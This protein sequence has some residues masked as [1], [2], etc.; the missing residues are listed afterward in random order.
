MRSITES[1]GKI[2]DGI[3]RTPVW[4]WILLFML[5]TMSQSVVT[6]LTSTEQ[7]L[8]WRIALTV[9]A[10]YFFT[11]LLLTILTVIVLTLVDADKIKLLRKKDRDCKKM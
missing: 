8:A 5:F 6:V 10:I 3:K 7:S 11:G 9:L 1:I 2:R 4:Y